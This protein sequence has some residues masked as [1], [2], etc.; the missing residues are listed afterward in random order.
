MVEEAMNG[1]LYIREIAYHA[2][3]VKS[4]RL[5]KYGHYPV[6]SMQVTTLALVGKIQPMAA[7]NLHSL[8]YVVHRLKSLIVNNSDANRGRRLGFPTTKIMFFR[9]QPHIIRQGAALLLFVNTNN[10]S[11]LGS[12]RLFDTYSDNA[13]LPI[14]THSG[15]D[16]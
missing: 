2:I 10:R 15:A 5:A 1:I 9:R 6:V 12:P 3:G 4:F 7:G 11:N 16:V 14:K 13:K 8:C